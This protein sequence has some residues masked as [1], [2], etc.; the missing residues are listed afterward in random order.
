MHM[1]VIFVRYNLLHF[2]LGGVNEVII[3]CFAFNF[4]QVAISLL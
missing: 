3:V 1:R 4:V 2:F